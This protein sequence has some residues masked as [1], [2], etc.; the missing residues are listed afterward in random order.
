MIANSEIINHVVATE[1][2]DLK[3]HD[4]QIKKKEKVSSN[5][6]SDAKTI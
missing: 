3:N 5:E 1:V 2:L 4:I 6:G